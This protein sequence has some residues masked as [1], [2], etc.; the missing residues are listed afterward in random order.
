MS[1]MGQ[2]DEI[3]QFER[4]F[5]R[6]TEVWLTVLI[7]VSELVAWKEIRNGSLQFR[8]N[9]LGLRALM[10]QVKWS[11][12]REHVRLH[13]TMSPYPITSSSLMLLHQRKKALYPQGV[14]QKMF[15]L[16]EVVRK[17]R[18][19]EI[20]LPWWY[21]QTVVITKKKKTFIFLKWFFLHKSAYSVWEIVNNH[22]FIPLY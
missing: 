2:E 21:E 19:Q 13:E 4:S 5:I 22:L 8:V 9:A 6:N 1:R 14:T 20:M 7:L 10:T 16:L 3:I 12:C 15:F 17:Y 18:L 11:N